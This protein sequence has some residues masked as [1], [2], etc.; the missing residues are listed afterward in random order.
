MPASGRTEISVVELSA[1]DYIV[2]MPGSLAFSAAGE[3]HLI[4]VM[5]NTTWTA[6]VNADW[7]SLSVTSGTNN[8]DIN[9]SCSTNASSAVRTATVSVSGAGQ[10]QVVSITQAAG[11]SEQVYELTVSP[12]SLNFA[13]N[14]GTQQVAVT[15][16]VAW[17]VSVDVSWINILG[18]SGSGNSSFY[19][20]CLANTSENQRTATI[21]VSGGGMT[22]TVSVTQ[23]GVTPTYS[24]SVSPSNIQAGAE[25]GVHNVSVTS[26]TSWTVASNA[27]WAMVSQTS[28]SGN[29]NF[30]I[31]C[32]ANE[33]YSVR[34]ATIT[35]SGGGL[36]RTVSI[37]QAGAQPP[38]ASLSVSPSSLTFGATGST[39]SV[40]VTSNIQWNVSCSVAW[41]TISATSGSGNGTVSITCSSNETYYARYASVTFSGG[42]LTQ[43]V[44]LSQSGAEQPAYTLS[45][46]PSSLTFNADGGAQ[47]VTVTSNTQWTALS[48]ASWAIPST[49]SWTGDALVSITCLENETYEART[50]SVFFSGGGLTQIV[51]IVQAGR[52]FVS[53]DDGFLSAITLPEGVELSPSFNPNT[54]SYS[55]SIPNN[56]TSL[57]VEVTAQTNGTTVIVSGNDNLRM[58]H[59][60]I[61]ITVIA[62]D[63]TVRYT[64][65]KAL[66]TLP[67]QN[68][69]LENGFNTWTY[70]GRLYIRADEPSTLTVLTPSGVVVNRVS[71]PKGETSIPL[72]RGLY[73]LKI[74]GLGTKTIISR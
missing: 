16:N 15:S 5:S 54:F 41:V 39:Q 66:R 52:T 61:V 11:S 60:L 34:T 73:I 40:T 23:A 31:T 36:T 10:T 62:T 28:G 13:I 72:P 35:V 9:V 65:I 42:G 69:P 48:S 30:N 19:V 67:D 18:N 32:L 51:N 56:I 71:F 46:S 50:A 45:V 58:G 26:N 14:A 70:S 53:G 22:R 47:S 37:T 49:Y 44:S 33:T 3:S 1:P 74:D 4:N 38:T 64:T 8:G 12:T 63:G 7:V 6:S 43:T 68:Y 17:T 57:A 25:G 20:A 59:D 21:T 2:V 24:L 27:A 29:A 55:I